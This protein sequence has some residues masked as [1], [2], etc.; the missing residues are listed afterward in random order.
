MMSSSGKVACDKTIRRLIDRVAR[1][2]FTE[3]NLSPSKDELSANFPATQASMAEYYQLERFSDREE[4]HARLQTY[5]NAKAVIA[6]WDSLAG[7]SGQ[8]AR[9]TLISPTAASD[10]LG[11]GLPWEIASLAIEKLKATATTSLPS[12]Q[13][14]VEGWQHGKSPGGV[15]ASKSQ[16]FVDA[17]R[18]IEASEHEGS[19]E[20]D[21]LLRRLSVQLF[22]DSKRIEALVRP[23]AFVLNDDRILL[24]GD[25]VFANLGLVKHPQPMLISGPSSCAVKLEHQIIPLARPYLGLRPDTLMNLEQNSKSIDCVMTIENLASFNEAAQDESNLDNLLL[26]YVAGNPTPSLLDAYARI[27]ESIS[28]KS[29]MHWGDIDVGG[30]RIASRLAD[31]AKLVGFDLH[32][33]KMN[34]AEISSE[35]AEVADDRKIN[36]VIQICEKHGWRKELEGLKKHPIFQ[37]QEF[38]VWETPV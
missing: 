25:S 10:L 8:L 3:G 22:G 2:L 29:L 30:F 1:R 33:W 19:H 16:Q 32:L 23:I 13:K 11:I 37:E 6:D 5:I 15:S 9:I 12:V 27:I 34:S 21:V 20:K 7:E 36:E 18:V 31:K 35:R 38:T 26:I 4:Y 24:E 17:L 14:I 28:P